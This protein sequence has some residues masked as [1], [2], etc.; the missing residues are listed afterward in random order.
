MQFRHNDIYTNAYSYGY[1]AG[2]T[3]SVI[4][5]ATNNTKVYGNVEIY[6]SDSSM[7]A[8]D[9]AIGAAAKSE[10]E[11]SY[12]KKAE[13][14][15]ETVTE[16]IKQTVTR[17]K[18][19]IEKVSEK[20]CKKLPWPLNKIVKW[21][22]KTIVKVITWVEEIVVE[23]ILQS[24]TDKKENGEYKSENNVILNGNIYYGSNA[25]VNI[26]IDEN[27][28]IANS[29]V[30]YEKN[31]DNVIIKSFSSKANG[32]LKIES[33]Y[34]KSKR[35]REDSQQQCD[36]QIKYYQQLCEESDFEKYRSFSRVRCR[37]LRVH[38]PLQ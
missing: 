21:I 36:H 11:V 18:N 15:A 35:N 20:I 37:Q 33:L 26:V 7:N 25:D 32:S 27:G 38:H 23:K 5:T 13:Y 10:S 29:D 31:G 17:T 4:S 6:G 2:G 16:F 9:I 30:T 1:T 28:N 12:T 24:A 8:K 19:V 22:T 14:K 3:G 34:G